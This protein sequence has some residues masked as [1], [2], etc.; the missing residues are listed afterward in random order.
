VAP[1]ALMQTSQTVL[2]SPITFRPLSQLW[3]NLCPLSVTDSARSSHSFGTGA[4]SPTLTCVCTLACTVPHTHNRAHSLSRSH[5]HSHI[6]NYNRSN[7]SH[8]TRTS[9]M[10][11]H[12]GHSHI[13]L[14]LK[15]ARTVSHSFSRYCVCYATDRTRSRWRPLF[16]TI[17]LAVRVATSPIALACARSRCIT[18]AMSL[19]TFVC[20]RAPTI[21]LPTTT[22]NSI[23]APSIHVCIRQHTIL[24]ALMNVSRHRLHSHHFAPNAHPFAKSLLHN[25]VCS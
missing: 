14:A 20:V 2:H 16:C 5:S 21:L 22:N 10:P 17:V 15:P 18:R 1:R 8:F 9:P 24:L 6:R 11:R 13:I 12:R 25:R 3:S 19:I 23:F 4:T 7:H